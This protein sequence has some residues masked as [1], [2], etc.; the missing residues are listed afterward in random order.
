MPNR[1]IKESICVS[2]SIDLLTWKEEVFFYRLITQCDDY[3]RFDA[4]PAVIKGRCFPLKKD[5]TEKDIES[6]LHRLSTV[7]LVTLYEVREKPFLQLTTWASHQQVRAKKSKY[8]APENDTMKSSDIIC[9]QLISNVPVI[10]SNPIQYEIRNPI[11]AQSSQGEKSDIPP[12]PEDFEIDPV[13]FRTFWKMYSKFNGKSEKYAERA[14]NAAMIEAEAEDIIA[15]LRNVI[16]RQWEKWP[17]TEYTY[18][19]KAENW[20]RGAC[21]KDRIDEYIPKKGEKSSVLPAYYNSNPIRGETLERITEEELRKAED[22][23]KKMGKGKA[24]NEN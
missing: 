23:L 20:L 6:M 2:E 10:Q 17:K 15:G 9:N 22:H 21:W 16:T 12:L 19:P 7:G 8:P 1:L 3:G 18:I 4:R 5:L 14:F 24:K 11:P 13:P